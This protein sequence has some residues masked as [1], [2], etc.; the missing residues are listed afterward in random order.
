MYEL[1]ENQ[2]WLIGYEGR[3]FGDT[4][5]EIYSL[6]K[7]P[8]PRRM[9]GGTVVDKRR[10]K[11]GEGYRV[12][13][14]TSS[15]GVV[16]NKYFHRLIAEAFIPN[17]E[18]KPQVNHINGIKTDN[19]VCN[20]EWVT[21]KENME[22]AHEVIGFFRP[23]VDDEKF[24]KETVSD[25]ILRG[26]TEDSNLGKSTEKYI[27]DSDFKELNIPPGIMNVN[28]KSNLSYYQNWL[29]IIRMVLVSRRTDINSREKGELLGVSEST[30]SRFINGDRY[31]RYFVLYDW[32]CNKGYD[33]YIKVHL[34]KI[35][36]LYN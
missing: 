15:D 29:R 9:K 3:Y 24:R 1:K 2:R 26:I 23:M 7:Y 34:D 17:P 19:R 8:T 5:G 10:R 20:L 36:D 25:Y 35:K 11:C 13:S 33:H 31:S 4:D 32:A 28:K 30:M 18:N 14:I 12:F 16:E 27:K 22:H 6:V 21:A